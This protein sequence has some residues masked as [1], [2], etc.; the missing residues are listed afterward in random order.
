MGNGALRLLSDEKRFSKGELHAL[1][2]EK[3]NSQAFERVADENETV[4]KDDLL[5][6][7]SDRG[8]LR[9]DDDAN[10][11][12]GVVPPSHFTEPYE[13]C[14]IGGGPA[15][16]SAAMRAASLGRRCLIVDA[17]YEPQF[18]DQATGVD[19]FLGAPTGLFS[20]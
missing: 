4:S 6:L 16:L 14:V 18:V 20:K 11:P 2:G 8:N 19:P 15:G 10:L 1:A 9:P 7:L 12:P 17:P 5:L 3:F 13:L